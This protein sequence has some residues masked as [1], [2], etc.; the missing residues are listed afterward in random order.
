MHYRLIERSLSR[1]VV[2]LG[3]RPATMRSRI[4]KRFLWALPTR[5][6]W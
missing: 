4:A 2:L 1:F 6:Q 3:R 5:A